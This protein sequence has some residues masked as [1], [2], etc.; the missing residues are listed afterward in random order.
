M[1]TAPMEKLRHSRQGAASGLP[2]VL[3]G[4]APQGH[5]EF[6]WLCMRSV[7]VRPARLSPHGGCLGTIYESQFG[8]WR[9]SS[10]S[11]INRGDKGPSVGVRPG[12][13]K[14]LP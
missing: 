5:P 7:P 13:L 3:A 11:D 8:Q 9:G 14:W 10:S 2:A 4:P 6:A 1:P 12:P